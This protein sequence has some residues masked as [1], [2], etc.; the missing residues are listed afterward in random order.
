MEGILKFFNP[1][2]F[3]VVGMLL[4][5]FSTIFYPFIAEAVDATANATS[6]YS[7]E[8]WGLLWLYSSTRLLLFVFGLFAI[9]LGVG[10]MWLRRK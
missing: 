8:Y 5:A 9:L 3:F 10:I 2:L 4:L 6:A 1:L 7:G